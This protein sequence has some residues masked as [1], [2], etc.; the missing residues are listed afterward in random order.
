MHEKSVPRT[1]AVGRVIKHEVPALPDRRRMAAEFKGSSGACSHQPR[2]AAS[3]VATSIFFIGVTAHD[4]L[5]F[6][7]VAACY[8]LALR[9]THLDSRTALP[10]NIDVTFKMASTISNALDDSSDASVPAFQQ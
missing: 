10:T 2:G 5:T 6:A 9:A 1:S 4:P 7:A 8:F 3:M